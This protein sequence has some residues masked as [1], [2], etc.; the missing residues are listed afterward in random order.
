VQTSINQLEVKVSVSAIGWNGV[1]QLFIVIFL[2]AE[3]NCESLWLMQRDQ[4][5]YGA[6]QNLGYEFLKAVSLL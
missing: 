6:S 1:Q 3:K 2:I 5:F 4:G